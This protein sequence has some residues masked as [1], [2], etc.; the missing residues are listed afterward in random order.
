MS[1][2]EQI[3]SAVADKRVSYKGLVEAMYA[4]K[5]DT[6]RMAVIF[7][8]IAISEDDPKV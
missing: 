4:N 8:N 5:E 2:F 1:T 3:V 6:E 7:N